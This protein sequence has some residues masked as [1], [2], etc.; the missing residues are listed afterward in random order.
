MSFISRDTA[1]YPLWPRNAIIVVFKRSKRRR[2]LIKFMV[3]LYFCPLFSAIFSAILLKKVWASGLIPP[4]VEKTSGV[5]DAFSISRTL[6]LY[7]TF[8]CCSWD[9]Y[10]RGIV[11]CALL[12]GAGAW[13]TLTS[14]NAR[15]KGLHTLLALMS[16]LASSATLE[17]GGSCT[18]KN[19][20]VA[21]PW[22][23][24]F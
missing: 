2:F 10:M 7:A 1:L 17:P 23:I 19:R 12:E 20:A 15:S 16:S 13:N 21:Q 24:I 5:N 11:L 22:S 14:N 18:E 9:L 3:S 8:F 4:V 6:A